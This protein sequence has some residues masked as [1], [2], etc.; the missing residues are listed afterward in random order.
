MT[1]ADDT[2]ADHLRRIA[3]WVA[4][5]QPGAPPMFRPPATD[6]QIAEVERSIGLAF[7]PG[8]RALY[9]L[10]DGQDAAAPSLFHAF[11]WMPL[12]EAAD[13]ALFLNEEFPDGINLHHPDHPPIHAHPGVQPCWWSRGWL[14]FL[15][16][17]GGDYACCDL[18]PAAGGTA[19]QV[20]RYFH[21]WE[22]RTLEARS[23]DDL[24]R[25]VSEGLEAGR[26][27][28]RDGMITVAGEAP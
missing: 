1:R 9:L 4:R 7:P 24:I 26:L 12:A 2:P 16:N 20:V 13:A 23:A 19:G 18:D 6:T 25:T 5:N 22:H 11:S 15:A 17:G 21:D 28:L 10:A 3:S 14:P 8:L 27:A